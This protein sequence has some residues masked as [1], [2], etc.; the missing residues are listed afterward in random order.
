MWRPKALACVL[1]ILTAL[2]GV[3]AMSA[4]A[5]SAAPATGYIEVE[6]NVPLSPTTNVGLLSVTL[7]SDMPITALTVT[8]V[9]DGGGT[10]VL[11]LP[12]SDF[13]VPAQDGTESY[14]TW[15]LTSPITTTELPIGTYGVDVSA[16]SADATITDVPAGTLNFLNEVTFPDFTSTGTTFNYFN[17]NVTFSG[18]AMVTAPGGSPTPFADESLNVTDGYA[19]DAVTTAGDG[20]FSATFP[21][22]SGTFYAQYTGTSTTAATNSDF[23]QITVTP[24][25]V[26]MKAS[27]AIP[28]ARAGQANSVRGT[29]TY[30]DGTAKK[31]LAGTTVSLYYDSYYGQTP[32]ATT[33]TSTSGQFTLPLPKDQGT[34]QWYVVSTGTEY[35]G[36]VAETLNVTVAEPTYLSSFRASLSAF[37]QVHASACVGTSTGR[38]EIEYASR[39]GGPWRDLGRLKY[40]DEGCV[41]GNLSGNLF[42]GTLNAVLASAYY[43]AVYVPNYYYEGVVTRSVHLSRTLTRITGF[44]IS[45]TRAR[46]GSYFTASGRLWTLGKHNKWYAYGHRKVIVVFFYQ[47]TPYR[48]PAAP[49]TSSGGYFRGRFQVVDTTPVFAQYNG[50]ATH[51]ASASK[52]IK[53]TDTGGSA[54]RLIAAGRLLPAGALPLTVPVASLRLT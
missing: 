11:T 7:A 45:P 38:V 42:S 37:A 48:Y 41:H 13:S 26:T 34:A 35:F 32:T 44:R 49:E 2:A 39:P 28:H 18:T 3:L 24:L 1:A 10:P 5:A 6:T 46:Y 15:T 51:F 36:S 27:V 25:P 31:P 4:A 20:T 54:A 30:A 23:I 33:V 22:V 50:D 8:I 40:Q 9:P 53:L 17:Q 14:G 19:S 43:R 16:A 29:L 12:M 21:A 47:G 52:R